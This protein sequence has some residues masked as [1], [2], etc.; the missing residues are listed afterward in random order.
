M[1]ILQNQTA[2]AVGE[3]VLL[4]GGGAEV[5]VF[6]VKGTYGWTRAGDLELLPEQ[7]PV[8]EV[9]RFAGEPARSGL[10][11]AAELTLAKPLVDVLVAGEIVLAA[12]AEAVDCTLEVGDRLRKTVR[13]S[14]ERFWWAGLVRELVP[15]RPAPFTRMPIAWERSYGGTDP[16]DPGSLEPRNPAGLGVRRQ[17]RA[18]EATPVPNFEDPRRPVRSPNDG[19]LPV[20]FGPIAPHWRPR[21]DLAGTYDAAWKETRFPRLPLDF[22]PRFVNAAPSDQQLDGY[23]PGEEVRL[24]GMT[25][26]GRDRFRLPT[27]APP[28]TVADDAAI[29]TLE[30]RVD[31]IVIRP[32]ERQVSLVARVVYRPRR[33]VLG[34]HQA[35]VG[36]L[37][38]GQRRSLE[39]GKPYVRLGARTL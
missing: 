6:V 14:G 17:A 36:E 11:E 35:Y 37:S 25:A 2:F 8:V 19:S 38:R 20:G 26:S 16:D 1:P 32:A 3:A 22:D 27:L 29:V 9:D 7:R 13:V 12:P 31:T 18:L 4:D 34:V 10:S 28:V 5:L 30:P 39:S 23:R 24:I 15:S 21:I 33:E